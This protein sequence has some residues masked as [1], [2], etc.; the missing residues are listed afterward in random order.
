MV[1]TKTWLRMTI[2]ALSARKMLGSSTIRT[3]HL[4][5]S[6]CLESRQPLLCSLNL[7]NSQHILPA[8]SQHLGTITTIELPYIHD[9]LR[10]VKRRSEIKSLNIVHFQAAN[11][12]HKK[13]LKNIGC[14]IW[15]EDPPLNQFYSLSSGIASECG[16]MMSRSEKPPWTS[17]SLRHIV[18]CVNRFYLVRLPH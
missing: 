17:P 16:K 13:V 8:T 6:L 3:S 7:V 12:N 10:G 15:S 4:L 11:A 5:A 14:P 2:H 18:S 1:T 9:G